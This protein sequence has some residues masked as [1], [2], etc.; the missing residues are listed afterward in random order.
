MRRATFLLASFTCVFLTMLAIFQLWPRGHF[1][2]PRGFDK[3][4][5][6]LRGTL[7]YVC[8]EVDK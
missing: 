6:Y 5:V 8:A 3:Q 1:T 2:C 4:K 7:I